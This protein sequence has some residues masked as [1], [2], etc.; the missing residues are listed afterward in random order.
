MREFDQHVDYLSR[1][2]QSCGVNH[3]RGVAAMLAGLC[4]S[5]ERLMEHAIAKA[6]AA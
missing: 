2:I 6:G 4:H 1:S 3:A 5:P